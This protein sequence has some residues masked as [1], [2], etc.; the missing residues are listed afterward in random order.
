MVAFGVLPSLCASF[1]NLLV[2]SSMFVTSF[3]RMRLT[4]ASLMTYL[5]GLELL[6]EAVLD[7]C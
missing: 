2:A 7:P 5:I 1:C 4:S 3:V 6:G